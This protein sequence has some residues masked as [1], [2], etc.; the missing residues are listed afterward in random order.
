MTDAAL[1]RPRRLSR[2]VGLVVLV[3]FACGGGKQGTSSAAGG[4]ANGVPNA[5]DAAGGAATAGNG[6][7]SGPE[8]SGNAAIPAAAA[9][10]GSPTA[11]GGLGAGA[12]MASAG[13]ASPAPP[14]SG[15]LRI[16]WVDT[17]GG[18]STVIAAPDGRIIVVDVGFSS[19]DAQRVAS[20]LNNELHAS[21]IDVLIVTHYHI[22]H[23]GGVP[24]L[25]GM[26]PVS[27]FFDHGAAVE[28]G[29]HIDAYM[30][31]VSAGNA[32]RTIVTPGQKLSF[33]SLELTFVTA[34]EQVI[35]P[36]LPSAV[37]NDGCAN[38]VSKTQL[39]GA[40]NPES[41]GFLARFG[42]FDFLDLGDFTWNVEQKL[43]CPTNRVGVVDLYQV[44]HH[45]MD[46]SSSPELVY[47]LKPLVAVMNNGAAKGGAAATFELLKASPGLQ[48][49]WSLHHVTAN[50]AAHNADEALTANLEGADQAYG[51]SALVDAG[52]KFTL[53][54]ARTGMSRSYQAR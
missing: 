46:L 24:T 52:G 33:G 13:A 7:T 50:D 2:A 5:G 35:E 30:N 40:E 25:A 18:A 9:S 36:P 12:S 23:V 47:S 32:K 10:N 26:F 45:G 16:Y 4:S 11:T 8:A 48:D 34:A 27:E 43:A 1:P 44:S 51:L 37:A 17:E 31:L 15:T 54:N 6:G 53:T 22:D 49:L 20:L 39:A 42:S 21:K 28:S 41:V 38:P 29:S 3:V 14:A 19:R